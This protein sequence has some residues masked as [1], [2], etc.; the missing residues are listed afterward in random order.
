MP[1]YEYR[2]RT[3]DV[4]FEVQQSFAED[5]L[6]LCPVADS[7]QSPAACV[8]PGEGVVRKIF[9]APSITF[10]GDGFYKTDSRSSSTRG[11][12]GAKERT[13]PEKVSKSD[14][15]ATTASADG[16]DSSGDGKSKSGGE[17]KGGGESKGDRAPAGATS[18]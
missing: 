3:C 16:K 6:T 15:G 14:D 10:K 1:T 17:A 12:N 5:S 9:S 2:C 7:A 4:S 11:G 18:S 8:A 13:S